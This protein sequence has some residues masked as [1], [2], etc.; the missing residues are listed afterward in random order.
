MEGI[1]QSV[2]RGLVCIDGES[3]SRLGMDRSLLCGDTWLDNHDGLIGGDF[4]ICAVFVELRVHVKLSSHLP[5]RFVQCGVEA[6]ATL[7]RTAVI[8]QPS[9]GGVHFMVQFA[10]SIPVTLEACP[11]GC[12]RPHHDRC[13]CRRQCAVHLQAVEPVHQDL[14]AACRSLKG[15]FLFAHEPR[16]P[17]IKGV[18]VE[19]SCQQ[20]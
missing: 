16:H 10:V 20:R 2:S 14:L 1:S 19:S 17:S 4:G 11:Q 18:F 9:Q 15:H 13:V 3:K 6:H 7:V 12:M 8:A 5:K